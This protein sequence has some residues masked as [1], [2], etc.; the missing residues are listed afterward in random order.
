MKS[1]KNS[2]Q[3]TCIN[4]LGRKTWGSYSHLKKKAIE[5]EPTTSGLML[6]LFIAFFVVT[7]AAS[8]LNFAYLSFEKTQE[9]V[10]QNKIY[11]L[12]AEKINNQTNAGYF[13]C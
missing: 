1:H 3:R 13:V 2:Q 8:V 12:E 10:G 4:S 5:H 9:Q 11:Y 7:S 6:N